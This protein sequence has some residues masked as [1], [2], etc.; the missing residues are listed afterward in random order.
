MLHSQ[1]HDILNI[2]CSHTQHVLLTHS[3]C[4]VDTLNMFCWHTQHVTC[5][6]NSWHI[7]HVLLTDTTCTVDTLDMNCW[8]IQPVQWQIQ[9]VQWHSQSV[10]WHIQSVQWHIQFVWYTDSAVIKLS[11]VNVWPG[12][13]R[14]PC[15]SPPCPV[16]QWQTG[17]LLSQSVSVPVYI[18]T[19]SM[20]KLAHYISC[21]LQCVHTISLLHTPTMDR[22]ID[23]WQSEQVLLLT[24]AFDDDQ[25]NL[26]CNQWSDEISRA[27]LPVPITAVLTPLGHNHYVKCAPIWDKWGWDSPA[28]VPLSSYSSPSPNTF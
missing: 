17:A 3:T 7:Q 9:Y 24:S 10:Q 20:S 22:Q 4:T 6:V 12:P 14:P 8:H 25:S 23:H 18:S 21:H 1:V 28:T 26:S 15:P 19:V 11:N 2:Y 16:L 27:S 13:R 5:A